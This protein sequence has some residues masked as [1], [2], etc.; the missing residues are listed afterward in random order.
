MTYK[1]CMW[2]LNNNNINDNKCTVH[3]K[4]L[5]NKFGLKKVPCPREVEFPAT[6]TI[7]FV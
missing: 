5:S 2:A 6:C 4:G 7:N 3:I 1:H